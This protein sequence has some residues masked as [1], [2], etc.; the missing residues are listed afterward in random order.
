MTQ[1]EKLLESI[2]ANPKNVRFSDLVKICNQYFGKPRQQ[3]TSHII[4]K[5]PWKGDPRINIQKDKDGKAKPYQ[6]MQVIAAINKLKGGEK[7]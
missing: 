1:T 5:I 6:V 2:K 4:Y 7:W 3:G